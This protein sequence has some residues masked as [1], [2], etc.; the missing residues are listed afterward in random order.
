VYLSWSQPEMTNVS[1]AHS[2]FLD[3][4]AGLVSGEGKLLGSSVLF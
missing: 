3:N 2:N 1:I 4:V